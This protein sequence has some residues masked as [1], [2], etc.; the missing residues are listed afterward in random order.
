VGPILGRLKNSNTKHFFPARVIRQIDGMK[1]AILLLLSAFLG[2]AVPALAGDQLLLEAEN[3]DDLGGWVVDQQ[4]MDQMG[5]PF[6]LAHGLG[7]PVGDASTAAKLPS[8][9]RYHVWVR[10]RDW[11]APWN[12]PG[13]PGKF[14]LL[15]NGNPLA[16][17]FGTEGANW[18]WQDGGVVEVGK[19][20]KV[21]L[22]D[23]MGLEGRCDA[24]LFCKDVSFQPPNGLAELGKFRRK[25]LGLPEKPED[26]GHFDLI[27]AGGG[28]AGTC[29]ALA[30][31][32]LGLTVALVQDRPVLG[33][34]GSSEVRVW[35][36]GNINQPPY[37]RVGDV[38]AELVQV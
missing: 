36:E 27:V 3:F 12:A 28:M 20:A 32:R 35:P 25:L 34:N 19:T 18:H 13:T 8:V 38:V 11:V 30:A 10:T 4:F 17:T 22:H 1:T 2:A 23:L 29:M 24:V 16:T 5:S 33:G 15:I 6:L 26:G 9:G 31:A 14:Q 21:A 7:Y 37:P